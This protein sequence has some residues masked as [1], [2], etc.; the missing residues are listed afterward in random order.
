[1]AI[2][3]ISPSL[4]QSPSTNRFDFADFQ[5][6]LILDDAAMPLA[7]AELVTVEFSSRR[8][9]VHQWL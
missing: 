5:R 8:I 2:N 3:L 7:G 6:A 1:V 9:V 4:N